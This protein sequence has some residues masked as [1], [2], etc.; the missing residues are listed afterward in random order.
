MKILSII[1]PS[2][3]VEKYLSQTMES[4]TACKRKKDIDLIIVNDDSR[5]K[6]L[7]IIMEYKGKYPEIITV[8]N[9]ENGGHGSTINSGLKV[10]K[11]KFLAVVDGDDWVDTKKLDEFISFIEN[12]SADVIITGHYRDYI[13]TGKKETYQYAEK[14][15]F[16]TTV[17]YLL[18]KGYR[19]PMTDLCYKTSLLREVNL[20]LQKNTFYVDEEF[21]SYPFKLVR[22]V[23][24]FSEGFYHY[25][26]GDVNQSISVVNS[27]K[28]IDHKLRV[29]YRISKDLKNTEIQPE[30]YEYIRRKMVGVA[31]SI[32]MIYYIYFPERKK[33]R[34]EGKIFYKKIAREY[35]EIAKDCNKIGKA[36]EFMNVF[37]VTPGAWQK[38]QQVKQSI[39]ERRK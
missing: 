35:P 36:F 10:A 27:V 1:V 11:G 20:E 18:K 12:Q 38:Y 37:G 21:C 7:S 15:G 30:N 32:L 31:N 29:F 13:N 24:F 39:F 3:N 17:D 6:T 33:G 9:K 26:I 4:I 5:D 22:S 2:Y 14:Q 8:I 28:R 23:M 16:L 19:L 25:R 34:K